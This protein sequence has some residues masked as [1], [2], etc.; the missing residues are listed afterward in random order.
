MTR[1]VLLYDGSCAFCTRWVAR[2][3]RLDRRGAIA[4]VPAAERGRLAWLPVVSDAAL[5]DAA[6]LVLPDGTLRRGARMLPDLARLVPALAWA[7]WLWAIPGVPAL[8]DR[9]YAQ[10]ARRRH[11]LGCAGDACAIATPAV[12]AA[13]DPSW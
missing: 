5:D 1:P 13:G 2:L 10:V 3:R 7:R 9:V 11:R 8:A 4:L 6:Y 12:T